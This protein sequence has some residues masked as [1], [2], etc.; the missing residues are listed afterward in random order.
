MAKRSD[1]I[2]PAQPGADRGRG[3]DTTAGSS[4]EDPRGI[5]SDEDD[6]FDDDDD[7]LED[8]EDEDSDDL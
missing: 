1:D 4:V 5:A 6:E 2:S 3:D 7:D 8:V